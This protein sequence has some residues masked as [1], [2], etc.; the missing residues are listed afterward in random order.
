MRFSVSWG[1]ALWVL[2]SHLLLGIHWGSIRFSPKMVALA[3]SLQ[4]PS[5]NKILMIFWGCLGVRDFQRSFGIS[6]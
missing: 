1:S 3:E 4:V 5:E 2:I 6:T